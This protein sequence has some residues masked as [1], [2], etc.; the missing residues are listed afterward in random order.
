MVVNTIMS[1]LYKC[2]D[3]LP[4]STKDIQA[5]CES[6]HHYHEHDDG[7]Y[8]LHASTASS[9]TGS[10]TA[11]ARPNIRKRKHQRSED[12]SEINADKHVQKKLKA[13]PEGRDWRNQDCLE[14]SEDSEDS[15]E[16]STAVTINLPNEYNNAQLKLSSAIKDDTEEASTLFNHN[17]VREREDRIRYNGKGINSTKDS[18]EVTLKKIRGV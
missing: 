2:G 7:C 10:P 4:L 9:S 18:A 15:D 16:D 13:T 5:V 8:R 1:T 3:I 12:S 6:Y 11:R 17:V 14:D